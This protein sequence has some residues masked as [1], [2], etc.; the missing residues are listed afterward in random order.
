MNITL[1][2]NAGLCNRLYSI[3]S[4]VSYAKSH[5]EDVIRIFWYDFRVCRSRF[6]DLFKN[7]IGDSGLVVEELPLSR[8]KDVPA[9][10]Y[11]LFL[12]YLIRKACYD[13]QFTDKYKPE[14]FEEVS[15]GRRNVYVCHCNEFWA[16][17]DPPRKLSD[18]FVP[19]PQIQEEIDRVC[20]QFS[21]RRAVG[22]HIRRTDNVRSIANSPVEGFERQIEKELQTDPDTVFYL[23]S[24]DLE[25]KAH[26]KEKYDGSVISPDFDLD[27]NSYNGIKCAVIDLFCLGR[28]E[29]IYG[30]FASTYSTFASQLFDIPLII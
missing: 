15:K 11:N 3:A 22:L 4:A 28:T 17:P 12:P 8:L 20:S 24:D 25:V 30:S 2:P 10:K 29:K 18:L 21:N 6:S 5:P 7:P 9:N 16:R 1:L 27:R 23:A 14:V 26:L 19:Q 13:L